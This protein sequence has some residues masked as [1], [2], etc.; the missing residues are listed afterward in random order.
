MNHASCVPFKNIFPENG[1]K[2]EKHIIIYAVRTHYI[3]TFT[4]I[5]Q[6]KM[7][8]KEKET[9]NDLTE[10]VINCC[11]KLNFA[12]FFLENVLINS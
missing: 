2:E 11:H 9:V 7:R 6:K 10:I 1:A 3:Y 12:F 4:H 8:K 5:T